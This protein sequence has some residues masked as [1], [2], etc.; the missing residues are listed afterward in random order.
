MEFYILQDCVVSFFLLF[1]LVF[2][3]RHQF[4]GGTPFNQPYPVFSGL[5]SLRPMIVIF[6]YF[7]LIIIIKQML[8][9]IDDKPIGEAS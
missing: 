2:S 5:K 9:K 7:V 3:S 1:C 4:I 6:E 8:A